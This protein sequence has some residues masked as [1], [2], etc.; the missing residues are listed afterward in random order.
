MDEFFRLARMRAVSIAA[1]VASASAYTPH[2]QACQDAVTQGMPFCDP[3]LPVATRAADFISRLTVAEKIGLSGTFTGDICAGVDGG[4]PRLSVPPLSCLIE[5]T[6]AVSSNCYVDESGISYCPTVFPAP[7]SVAASFNRSLMY[8]RGYVTG[9]EAR[10]FNNLNV[11]RVYG[12]PVD[13]LAFGPDLNLIVDPRNG[14]N[15]ENP[16]EDGYLAGQ[17][18]IQYVHGA[19]ENADDP[20]RLMLSMALKHFAGY[21]SETNRF[22]SDFAFS[23]FDLLDTFLVPYESGFMRGGAV[24]SMCSYASLNNVSACADRWLLT[25]M[26]REYWQR[27]DAYVMSD[28]GAVEDQFEDKKTASSYADAAAQSL[29]A[30]STQTCHTHP[31]ARPPATNP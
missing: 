16:T 13:L 15:G 22:D 31:P 29:S 17:Y 23:A 24:G 27:P 6:G 21:Q 10:A 18:A 9:S 11:N 14:R 25:S 3:S 20:S 30:A 2:G 19:Q 26:V 4:V 28:C 8:V 5:C 1:L 12:N 7:L